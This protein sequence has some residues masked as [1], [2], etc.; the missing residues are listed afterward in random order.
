MEFFDFEMSNALFCIRRK[1]E[2][3]P[4]EFQFGRNTPV[5][6]VDVVKDLQNKHQK[7]LF[8][9]KDIKGGVVRIFH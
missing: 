6:K 2:I 8:H 1:R 4:T 7:K 9:V 5:T 3:G